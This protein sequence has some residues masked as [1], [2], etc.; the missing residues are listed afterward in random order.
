MSIHRFKYLFQRFVDKSAS[1][2]ETDEFLSMMD[3][4]NYDE[5]IKE[6]LDEFWKEPHSFKSL[7]D[8]KAE[9]IFNHIISSDRNERQAARTRVIN[10]RGMAAAAIVVLIGIAVLFYRPF[11]PQ[12]DATVKHI[13]ASE[14]P[15]T[16]IPPRRFINLPDGSSVIL[17][18]NSK[19]DFSAF[20]K[21]GK[22]EVILTGEA[23]FDIIH[24]KARPFIVYTGKLRTTVLGTKFNIKASRGSRT[25]T[26]TVKKGKVKVGDSKRTYNYIDPNQQV[27]FNAEKTTYVKKAVK[28]EEVISWVAGDM[29]FDDV[30]MID[31]ANQLQERFGISIVFANELV[32]KCRFSATFLKTQSLE[33][34]L[35]IIGE[36]NNIKYQFRNKDTIVLDGAGCN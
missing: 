11:S 24:D 21:N 10:I 3:R 16:S 29:Y 8:G 5:K 30:S 1:K 9:R 4:N 17:N 27:V 19:L 23:F 25:V 36:F 18:G 15:R 35:N 28:S 6:L 20:N 31:V 26:V 32:K 13:R 34:I 14:T 7:E 22:R 2:E 12:T 33:Q